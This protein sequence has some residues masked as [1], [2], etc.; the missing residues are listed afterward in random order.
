MNMFFMPAAA[1]MDRLRYPAKFGIIFA[2]VLVPL[3]FLSLNFL[4]SIREEVGFI[5]NERMGLA[6][7][8]AVRQP[9][10]YIQQHRGM[11]AAYLNGAEEF[12]GRIMEKRAVVDKKLAELRSVDADL[13]GRL[14]VAGRVDALVRRWEEIK[15]ESM[16]LPLA[17]AVKLHSGLVQDLLGLMHDVADASQITLDP[18][19]D[20]YYL[21]DAVVYSLP[22][23]LENMGLARA[24]GSGVAAKGAFQDRETYTRLAV[25]LNNV[26]LYFERARS[27]LDAAFRSNAEVA[28]KLKAP[29]QRNNEAIEAFRSL[30]RGELLDAERIEVGSSEVFDAATR[31]ISGS[32]RL[33]DAIVPALDELFEQRIS[34]G[35]RLGNLVTF[36]VA[37]GLFLV[38]YFFAG[39]YFSVRESMARIN[40]G[41]GRL[42]DGDLTARVTLRARDEMREISESFNTMA[43]RFGEMVQQIA[44]SS[45]RIASSSE[46]L[47]S[48]TEQ[49]SQAMAGQQCQTEEMATAMQQM[50]ATVQEVS[51]NISDAARASQEANDETVEGRAMVENSIKAIEGLARQ[52]ENTAQVIHEVERNSEEISAIMDVIRTVAEQTNLLALNAAIEA[53]RAGEQGRGFAVV[54]DEVRTL[55]ARTQQSTEEINQMIEKLQGGSRKAVTVMNQSR[56]EARKAVEQANKAGASLGTIAEAVS[57]ISDMSTQIASAAEEQAA[58]A[59]EVTR[60]VTNIADM[61]AETLTGAQHTASAS[62]DLARL[63]GELQTVVNQFRV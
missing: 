18:V 51:R 10:E 36:M 13:G 57:R 42:A 20:S 3:L 34:E 12:K 29:T 37:A 63:A 59:E 11:T 6:Y 1:M 32:Y 25:L 62:E 40:E 17:D 39:F 45:H 7:I 23:M 55:A 49:T 54:A 41:A 44:D 8:N 14:G 38:A 22:N 47:S 28:G 4:A 26:D 2:L 19:L 9:I 43:A 48:V 53:A 5:E 61:T 60:N 21:G 15:A 30:V 56:D 52:I 46:E 16:G 35:R 27:G 50:G 31:A 33:Y 58:T 24:V